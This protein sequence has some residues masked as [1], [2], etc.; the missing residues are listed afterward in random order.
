MLTHPSLLS[1]Q[2]KADSLGKDTGAGAAEVV[3]AL[4][5]NP[6]STLGSASHYLGRQTPI[7]PVRHRRKSFRQQQHLA[8]LSHAG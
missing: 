7:K 1:F 3:V 5:A 8:A 4:S 2:L 6:D